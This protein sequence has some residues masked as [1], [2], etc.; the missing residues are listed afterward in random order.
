MG[1]I[2]EILEGLKIFQQHTPDE[3]IEA[4][5]DEITGPDKPDP[6]SKAGKQ[7]IDLGWHWEDDCDCWAMAV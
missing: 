7:L 1:N 3:W 6:K 5:F 4:D 2:T